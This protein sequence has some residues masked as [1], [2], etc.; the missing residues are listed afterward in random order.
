M[1]GLLDDLVSTLTDVFLFCTEV[2]LQPP[3][4][5]P[6]CIVCYSQ[7]SMRKNS[8]VKEAHQYGR[9]D[10]VVRFHRPRPALVFW[11]S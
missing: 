10:W 6:S 8:S 7:Y 5:F 3:V 1:A 9:S 2:F 4:K 11:E